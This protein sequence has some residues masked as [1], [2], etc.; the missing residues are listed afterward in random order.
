MYSVA[1][2][3]CFTLKLS[4]SRIKKDP[5]GSLIAWQRP[6]LAERKSATFGAKDLSCRETSVRIFSRLHAFSRQLF[7]VEVKLFAH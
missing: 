2:D 5:I 6:T 4:S 7:Y 3:N 1:T